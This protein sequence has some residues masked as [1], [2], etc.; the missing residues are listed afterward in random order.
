MTQINASEF[1]VLPDRDVTKELT[2]LLSHLRTVDGEKTVMLEK[3]S[4]RKIASAADF[5]QLCMCR[6]PEH[7]NRRQHIPEI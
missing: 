6:P 5:I 4:A 7:H 3:G 2:A 1:G